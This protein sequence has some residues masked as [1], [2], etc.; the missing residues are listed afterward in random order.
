MSN[1]PEKIEKRTR[2]EQLS[3]NVIENFV[4]GVSIRSLMMKIF[5]NMVLSFSLRR[6][7]QRICMTK[8]VED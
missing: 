5:L 4:R 6:D 1:R 3:L 2:K 7:S 8:S